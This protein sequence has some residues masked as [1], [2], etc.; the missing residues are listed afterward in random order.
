VGTAVNR[1]TTEDDIWLAKYSPE[2]TLQWEKDLEQPSIQMVWDVAACDDG[3]Y[4]VGFFSGSAFFNPDVP[5]DD[6]NQTVL[7]SVADSN[8]AFLAKYSSSGQ[9]QWVRQ[10]GEQYHDY[11]REVQVVDGVAYISG[12]L[13]ANKWGNTD[14]LIAKVNGMGE[15]LW[16]TTIDDSHNL[17]LETWKPDNEP[18]NIFIHTR[19][20]QNNPYVAKYWDSGDGMSHQWTREFS[21]DGIAESMTAEI[22]S[23]GALGIYTVFLTTQIGDGPYERALVKLNG[24]GDVV[25]YHDLPFTTPYWHVCEIAADVD[26]VY[27]TFDHEGQLDFD[28][29]G[30]IESLSSSGDFDVFLARYETADGQL[31]VAQ[32]MGGSA[33]DRLWDIEIV[34]GHVTATIQTYSQ[35]GE[36]PAGQLDP[37]TSTVQNSAFVPSTNQPEDLFLLKLDV[38]APVVNITS[39]A[40]YTEVDEGTAVT[41][42]GTTTDGI[43]TW[44][45]NGQPLE[46]GNTV[47]L[48]LGVG[49]HQISAIA[50]DGSHVGM[51]GVVVNVISNVNNPPVAVAD[52][53]QTEQDEMLKIVASGVLSNDSDP[54]GDTISAVPS[55]ETTQFGGSVVISSN[56]SF[57][58][59]PPTGF[60][61][62]D[63]F[64]Y[65]VTDGELNAQGTVSI[66]VSE[67][68]TEAAIYVYDIRFE[69]DRGERDWR[70]VFEIRCDSNSSGTGDTEDLPVAGAAITVEFAGRTYSGTTDADGIFRT[71]YVRNLKSG[72]YY[73]DVVD[74]MMADY[75]W[76]LEILGEDD[77]DGDGK[78]DEL[79][80]R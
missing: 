34:D 69:S 2:G 60:V 33:R 63:T 15:I 51:A 70:A 1:D 44:Y 46:T 55:S 68:L 43:I 19:D 8:D 30:P 22:D 61:G 27:L 65:T 56:G 13:S 37:D 14:S 80:V 58:Y 25:W 17:Q 49:T 78:P 79:L 7:H 26:T 57:T 52:S 36:F 74:L 39:P 18:T 9:F 47:S 23:T 45:E 5:P 53:Y 48:T 10:W 3:V 67:P 35:D 64:T 11:I 75:Y 76:D 4:V 77:S 12:G 66:T 62:T 20:R 16:E 42:S 24:S 32:R 50:T 59:A 31:R 71:D 54:D 38:H 41:L 6:P 28:G 29:A 21:V 40:A 72:T 73:A